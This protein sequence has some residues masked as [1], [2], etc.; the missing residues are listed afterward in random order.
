M[1]FVILASLAC[2]LLL[3]WFL[4]SL[5]SFKTAESDLLSQKNAEGRL[6][7]GSFLSLVASEGSL[8]RGLEKATPFAARLAAEKG[9]AG[10]LVVDRDGREVLA[11]KEDKQRSLQ[12]SPDSRLIR[13][14]RSRAE[15][16]RFSDDTLFVS[17]YAPLI[18]DG[19]VVGAARL[20]LSLQPE[21]DRLKKSRSIFAAYFVLDFILLLGFGSYLMSRLIVIPIRRL[22]AATA[23]IADGDLGQTV[24][25]PGS[26]EIADLAVA[27]NDMVKAL[28]ENRENVQR[29]VQSLEAVNRE[30]QSARQEAVRSEKMASI[31]LLAAG[32]AHEIG[33]PL[34]AIMGYAGILKD[35]LQGDELR[36]DY[37]D[38]IETAAG[39]IDRIIRNLLDYARPA[40]SLFQQVEVSVIIETTVEMLEAQG[41]FKKIR[42]SMGIEEDL[43][44][45]SV[46]PH[47]LQQ[48]LINILINARDAMPE[49]GL[50]EITASKGI[51][52]IIPGVVSSAPSQPGITMGRRKTDF[53]GAF[54]VSFPPEI[55]LLK[56]EISD[57]GEGISAENM[58]RVFDPFFT[59]KEPGQGTGLG[60]AI[61]ARIIDSFG[62]RISLESSKGKGS[63]FT[64]WL[65]PLGGKR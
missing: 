13:V 32:T 61:S 1:T 6:L 40:E 25:V 47:Q 9:F 41:V 50:V 17:R 37:V 30:L 54:S 22:L 15:E 38:R 24:Q 45:I 43:P 16:Y 23:R 53:S 52:G 31:G 19:N 12:P 29:H 14:Q 51:Y 35:E 18:I 8:T 64:I 58:E 63:K 34:G 5:I 4:L 2:L 21:H 26:A 39:R 27:F 7:L 10:L 46:D 48:V 44:R 11:V 36:S 60:L 62:G 3:T 49:G 55:E 56:I 33:T 28:K 42:K 65:P 57:T 20:S 59:T